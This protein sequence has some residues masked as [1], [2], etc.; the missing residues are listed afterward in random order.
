MN[1][2]ARRFAALAVLVVAAPWIA[3]FYTRNERLGTVPETIAGGV[4]AYAI[5]DAGT[6]DV[7]A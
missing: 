2:D 5:I 4:T 1:F 6:L 7:S 3:G